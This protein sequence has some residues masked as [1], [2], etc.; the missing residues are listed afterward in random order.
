MKIHELGSPL[1][2]SSPLMPPIASTLP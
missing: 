1:V 2:D